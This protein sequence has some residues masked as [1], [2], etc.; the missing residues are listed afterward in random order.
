M[1]VAESETPLFKILDLI[2]TLVLINILCP[3]IGTFIPQGFT[4]LIYGLYRSCDI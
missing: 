1:G 4:I 2:L 3:Y